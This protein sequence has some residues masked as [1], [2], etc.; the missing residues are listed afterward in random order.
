MSLTLGA[1]YSLNNSIDCSGIANFKPGG[2]CVGS[3]KVVIF[4]LQAIL[5]VIIQLFLT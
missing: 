3:R 2:Y 4:H 1:N 5:M